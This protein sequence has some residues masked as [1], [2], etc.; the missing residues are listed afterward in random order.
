MAF[1]HQNQKGPFLTNLSPS[2]SQIFL[3]PPWHPLLHWSAPAVSQFSLLMCQKADPMQREWS[4]C[5]WFSKLNQLTERPT[6]CQNLCKDRDRAAQQE[7]GEWETGKGFCLLAAASHEVG[8]AVTPNH[9]PRG[10]S[11][12]V[13]YFSKARPKCI[14]VTSSIV[15]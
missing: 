3:L 1:Y 7:S 5:S 2:S 14:K 9:L 11:S 10:F 12:G 8:S 4:L 13:A 15:T 6:T